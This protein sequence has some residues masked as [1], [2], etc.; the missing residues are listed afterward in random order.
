MPQEVLSVNYRLT[1]LYTVALLQHKRQNY[2][3]CVASGD[4]SG[5]DTVARAGFGAAG[6]STLSNRFFS[7]F[8]PYYRTAD[9]SF[10]GWLL[11]T[12][13]GTTWVFVAQGATTVSPSGSGAQ[14]LAFGFEIVGKN[15]NNHVMHNPIYETNALD[16]NKYRDYSAM[17]ATLK[18]AVD[19]YFNVGLTDINTD[20][21]AWKRSRGGFFA[22]RWLAVVT[23]TNEKLRRVRRIK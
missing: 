3:S 18:G 6:V 21:Y 22:T 10:N 2:L 4:A 1:F 13:S 19:Y 16:V 14:A 5:Y 17:S 15:S 12:R 9:C 8:A 20:A 23:D 7:T 11:E